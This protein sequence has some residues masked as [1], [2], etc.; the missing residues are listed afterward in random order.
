MNTQ[1]CIREFQRKYEGTYFFL[2]R[3]DDTDET[4]VYCQEISNNQDTGAQLVVKSL[5][6]GTLSL[7]IPSEQT[8]VFRPMPTG[9][10][11]VGRQAVWTCRKPARQW[12][13]GI[14]SGN[15]VMM[16]TVRQLVRVAGADMTLPNLTKVM[17]RKTYSFQEG[18]QM[19]S[20]NLRDYVSVAVGGEFSLC[21]NTRPDRNVLLVLYRT[22]VVASYDIKKEAFSDG[23]NKA[24][25]PQLKK[26]RAQ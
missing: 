13:K 3:P 24:F 7:N 19:L 2:R 22:W 5:D 23:A 8:L 9:V 18:V 10:F 20:G 11:Q 4:L 26:L 16:P 14:C 25:L 17:E 1:E 6:F 21:H 15:S 12:A